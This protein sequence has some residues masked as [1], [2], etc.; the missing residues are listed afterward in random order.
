MMGPQDKKS[1]G[2]ELKRGLAHSDDVYISDNHFVLSVLLGIKI[3][4]GSFE[5]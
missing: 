2:S 1:C 5:H 3:D 4:C